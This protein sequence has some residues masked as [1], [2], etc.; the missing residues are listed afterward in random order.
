MKKRLLFLG[1]IL[2]TSFS[3]AQTISR[4]KITD[5]EKLMAKKDSVMVI[6][7][8]ATFCLPCNHEIPYFISTVKKYEK[9]KVKLVLVSLDLP[10][11][12]PT[13]I[14]KFIRQRKYTSAQHVWLNETNADYFCPKI[15]E[16]WSGAIPATIIINN[17]TGYRKFVED[18]LS[19]EAF[20][21]I[22]KEALK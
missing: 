1:L 17:R 7:F 10:D 12:Y 6:N 19:E 4:W 13:K 22:I 11:C 21:N 9:Q 5:V 20:E 3:Q 14:R 16:K 8:W 2:F 15:S 18:E